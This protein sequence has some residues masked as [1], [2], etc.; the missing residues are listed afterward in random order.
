MSTLRQYNGTEWVEIGLN[1]K[2]AF[3][4]WLEQG[5]SG[6]EQDFIASLK[7]EDGKDADEEQIVQKV[8]AGIPV[9]KDGRDGT[10]GRDVDEVAVIA[11]VLE[12][13]PTPRDGRD[14]KDAS[15]APVE[16]Y[17]QEF[18]EQLSKEIDRVYQKVGSKTYAMSELSDTQSATTGQVMIKQAD[19]S[20]AP[21]AA[22]GG[23]GLNQEIPSGTVNG[24]NVTFTVTVAPKFI[25][26]DTGTY[27]N[28]AVM[29][30]PGMAGFSLSGLTV[31]M[32]LA[33]N[34]F[35]VAYS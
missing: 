33:P 17:R 8:L 23:S 3:E 29:Q 27:I 22:T 18:S 30:N 28:T 14:G 4:V 11:K 25:I 10:N 26:T 5:N 31:T 1:G 2:S 19:G 7:G 6:S 32:D 20:W 35:L 16:E 13:I 24:T 9:P 12:K 34:F 15:P 21:G